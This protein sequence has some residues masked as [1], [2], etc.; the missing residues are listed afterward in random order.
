MLRPVD[1]R[2]DI[3]RAVQINK[4]NH[5]IVC[6][7]SKHGGA[8]WGSFERV[9]QGFYVP[10]QYRMLGGEPQTE[11]SWTQLDRTVSTITH[12][13]VQ[14]RTQVQQVPTEHR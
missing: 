7:S 10:A 2:A 1:N 9:H 6:L 11:P 14:S 8:Q 4:L 3:D 12:G 13:A 5:V